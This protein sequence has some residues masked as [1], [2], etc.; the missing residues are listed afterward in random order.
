[1]AIRCK[2]G[3][4][5]LG[6]T[7][8]VL[9]YMNNSLTATAQYYYNAGDESRAQG[10]IANSLSPSP[11]PNNYYYKGNAQTVW[12]AIADIYEALTP[13]T[14]GEALYALECAILFGGYSIAKIEAKVL[15]KAVG[16]NR[17]FVDLIKDIKANPKNWQKM[18]TTIVKSTKRGNKG[19]KSIEEVLVNKKTGE[20]IVRHT[21]ED[22]S[23]KVIDQH[24]RPFSKQ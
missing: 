11:I 5:F 10:D 6:G 7:N 20:T 14:N 4:G 17:A 23:G 1:M 19:G 21:L 13:D 2:G 15:G 18:R 22:K 12:G 3:G 24:Y 16:K 8:P 9:N